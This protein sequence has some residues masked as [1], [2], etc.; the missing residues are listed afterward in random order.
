MPLN[1]F[2]PDRMGQA[3]IDAGAS[4]TAGDWASVT[5]TY[6]AG[7]YGIDDRGGLKISFRSATDQTHFQC[8][9]PTAPG[10]VT[11]SCSNGSATKVWYESHR[12]LRPWHHTLYIQC[13]RYLAEGDRITV[14]FGDKSDGSPGFRLQT[15]C[16]RTFQF[17]VHVDPFATYDY[18]VLPEDKQ[19]TVRLVPGPGICWRAIL[20]TLRATGQSFA[21]GIKV[22]DRWGNPSDRVEARVRLRAS[23]AVE[24]LPST[25]D[26]TP[27]KP[28]HR[29]EGLRCEQ[30]GDIRID[31]FDQ[32]DRF[33]ARSNPLRIVD[34]PG[35]CHYWSDMH[36]QSGETIGTDTAED[37]F[38]FAR[39]LAFVDIAA[40]QAN[41][42]QITDS[43]WQELNTLTSTFDE[44]GRFLTVPGYEWSG[45]TSVGGDHN[46]WYREEGR[47][48]YRAHSYL[49]G[50]TASPEDECP[51]AADLFARLQGEDALVVAHV[52]GRF[53]DITYAHD[54]KLEPSVEIHSAWGTFEWI[55]EDALR[56]G[57]RIGIV[58]GSDEHKGRPGASYPG[59]AKFGAT[60]GLTCH[61]LPALNR[62]HLFTAFRRRRH[63]ATSG[64]RAYLDIR[65][66]NLIDGLAE[67]P[68]G[69]RTSINE[70]LMGDI[71]SSANDM[72][73]IKIDIIGDTGVERAELRDG[74]ETL[75]TFRPGDRATGRRL[76]VWCEGAETRGRG[77]LVDW[78][79][80]LSVIGNKLLKARPINFWNP[81]RQPSVTGNTVRWNN[82]TTGGRHAV[83]LTLADPSAGRLDIKS[84][85]I[86]LD[87][88]IDE[89]KGEDRRFPCGGLN[90]AIRLHRLSEAPLDQA[91]R[92]SMP[93]KCEAEKEQRLYLAVG[94]EDGHQAWTSPIYLLPE[95]P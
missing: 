86:D 38:T 15:F 54:A 45:N 84:N 23:D 93:L 75:I 2:H 88:A 19:P 79:V 29:I 14:R 89:I 40:H 48:I 49:V 59:A 32:K 71:I 55:V 20:P 4:L 91:F 27:S 17:R 56:E 46:V 47:P 85:Q 64:C 61:L 52:G 63:Y 16:E 90:K 68:D 18:V 42:F 80:E 95:R 28:C 94:F 73:T 66:P 7:L 62:D 35:F 65:I 11:V 1:P 76:R 81:E 39:D 74:L 13:L 25:L 34:H 36:G 44:P 77:R 69:S 22:E 9:D 82:V 8:E 67:L 30:V 53:A 72:V 21:L 78:E 83:D 50:E 33:L 6:T 87:L 60:G 41:D 43:F 37:Y 26:V 51:T 12:N 31:L 3:E 92:A 57:Y 10:Y 70:A 58:G 5:L 24:G